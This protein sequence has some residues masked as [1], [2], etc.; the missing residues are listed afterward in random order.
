MFGTHV[1]LIILKNLKI[2]IFSAIAATSAGRS[3]NSGCYLITKLGK[4]HDFYSGFIKMRYA[5]VQVL[6]LFNNT[7]VTTTSL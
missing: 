3:W 6:P 1:K 5:I 7:G 4:H 2:F